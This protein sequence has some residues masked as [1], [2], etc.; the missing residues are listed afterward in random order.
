MQ[1]IPLCF[2]RK[3]AAKISGMSSSWHRHMDALG[4]GPPKLRLG[5]GPGRIRYPIAEYMEWLSQ[6]LDQSPRRTSAP[7]LSSRSVYETG[8]QVP[9]IV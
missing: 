6:H 7:D 5:Q 3:Q 4:L 9:A 2:D 1:E 8:P